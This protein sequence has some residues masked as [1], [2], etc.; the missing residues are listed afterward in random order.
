MDLGTV[1]RNLDLVQA[2][3]T[4]TKV[5]QELKIY[6]NVGCHPV[7]TG[8][9]VHSTCF[10][11]DGGLDLRKVHTSLTWYRFNLVRK[12]SHL[13]KKEKGFLA[14]LIVHPFYMTRAFLQA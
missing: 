2:V 7:L 1:C 14:V 10:L 4:I 13:Q 12:K 11:R 9:S 5:K 6:T 8:M 3:H